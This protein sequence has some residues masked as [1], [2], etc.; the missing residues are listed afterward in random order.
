M[1]VPPLMGTIIAGSSPNLTCTVEL[2][3]VVNVPVTVN[4]VWNAPA[5]TT[6]T[7]TSSMMESLTRYTIVA[8]VDA[9]RGGNYTCRATLSSPSQFIT[10]SEVTS[11]S[12]TITVGE[13]VGHDLPTRNPKK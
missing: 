8:I 7:P 11:G 10:D 9:A 6:V 12:T 5:G 13:Y 2:S 4:A 1:I 3:P